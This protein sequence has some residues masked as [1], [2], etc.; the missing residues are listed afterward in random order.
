M[1]PLDWKRL[2]QEAKIVDLHIHPSMQQQL[3]RR[4]LNLRYVINRS[5]HGNPM[6]VRASF[7][8]LREG[9]YDVIFS[10]IYIPEYGILHDFPIVRLFRFLRPDLWKKL[11][12]AEPFDA[13]IRVMDDM[14]AAVASSS[15]TAPMK[16]A[17]STAELNAILAQPKGQRPIAVIHAVEGAHSLG[18]RKNQEDLILQH[19]EMFIISV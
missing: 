7:P 10:T 15:P 1:I 6:S 17:G 18:V 12:T 13:T 11:L 2:H 19:L 4:N 14:E 5:L 3:F 9:G 16:M 8:R